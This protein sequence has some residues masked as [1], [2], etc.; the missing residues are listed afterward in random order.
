MYQTAHLKVFLPMSHTY[1]LWLCTGWQQ[2]SWNKKICKHP[3]VPET[4]QEHRRELQTDRAPWGR[5]WEEKTGQAKA[6]IQEKRRKSRLW[7]QDTP[8]LKTASRPQTDR[9][10]ISTTL[11]TETK[12][13]TSTPQQNSW[14]PSIFSICSRCRRIYDHS[15]MTTWGAE[16]GPRNKSS[17]HLSRSSSSEPSTGLGFRTVPLGQGSHLPSPG[18]ISSALSFGFSMLGSSPFSGFLRSWEIIMLVKYHF[19]SIVKRKYLV[20]KLK[21]TLISSSNVWIAKNIS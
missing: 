10:T 19:K 11:T 2:S 5:D 7:R 9:F 6:G 16:H 21:Y 12:V 20:N 15:L 4:G 13:W 18:S 3:S 14:M 8:C 1:C 17:A